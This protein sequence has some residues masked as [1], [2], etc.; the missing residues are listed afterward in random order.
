M[1]FF[2]NNPRT[3]QSPDSRFVRVF[4][5]FG[6][7]RQLQ[8]SVFTSCIGSHCLID[9]PCQSFVQNSVHYLEIVAIETKEGDFYWTWVGQLT[10][11]PIYMRSPREGNAL[12][13]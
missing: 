12:P 11:F 1:L 2:P 13:D 3:R 9:K 5:L 8:L 4:H 10:G 7:K 6:S